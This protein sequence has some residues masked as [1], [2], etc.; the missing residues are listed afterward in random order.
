M[1]FPLTNPAIDP[2]G[3]RRA[4]LL[5][6]AAFTAILLLAGLATVSAEDKVA[7]CEAKLQHIRQN[8]EADR[9]GSAPTVLTEEEINA[10]LASGKVQLPKGVKSVR[11]S[12][13]PNVVTAHARVDF[14]KLTEGKKGNPFL[15]ALFTGVHDI[16][17]VADANGTGGT[18]VVHVQSVT[19]DGTPIP[20][21]ALEYLVDHYVKPKYPAAGMD[22][23]FRMGYRI[24]SAEVGSHKLTIRQK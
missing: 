19:L 4:T 6:V 13:A 22:S 5:R 14:D 18:G 7:S 2:K 16:V 11:F 12:G 23:R 8:A 15:M 10:Y 21:M 20:R 17:T 3:V 24:D 1:T 9:P